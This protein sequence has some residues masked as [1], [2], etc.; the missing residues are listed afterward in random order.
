MKRFALVLAVGVIVATGSIAFLVEGPLSGALSG[1]AQAARGQSLVL[2]GQGFGCTRATCGT[3]SCAY[4]GRAYIP[5]ARLFVYV[6]S[7][8][9]WDV[10]TCNGF[11]G[12]W[13]RVYSV[14]SP[15][16]PR[17]QSPLGSNA[18]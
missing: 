12:R 4:R 6:R 17:A 11:D 2:S 10:S 18:G 1:G 13:V 14:L 8:R 3:R 15:N 7:A 5:G 16:N 9:I